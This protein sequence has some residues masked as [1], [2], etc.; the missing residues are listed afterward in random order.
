MVLTKHPLP[1]VYQN[2]SDIPDELRCRNPKAAYRVKTGRPY[3]GFQIMWTH[4]NEE[5]SLFRV[6]HK[7][8]PRHPREDLMDTAS[9][10]AHHHI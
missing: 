6:Q 2:T 10:L 8:Y 4:C 9:Q 1:C 3:I 5:F 7:S